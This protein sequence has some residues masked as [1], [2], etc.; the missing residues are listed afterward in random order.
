MVD[1]IQSFKINFSELAVGIIIKKFFSLFKSSSVAQGV[2]NLVHYPQN[3][4]NSSSEL[5]TYIR[6]L[7]SEIR[8]KN[9]MQFN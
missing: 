6:I 9:L 2:S 8:F 4:K 1:Y 3:L 7:P 5:H